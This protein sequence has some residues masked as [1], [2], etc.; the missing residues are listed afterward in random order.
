MEDDSKASADSS[1]GP[2]SF[3]YQNTPHD[4]ALEEE[5]ATLRKDLE[6]QMKKNA[7]VFSRLERLNIS[8][9][10]L[11]DEVIKKD[12]RL[13]ALESASSGDQTSYIAGLKRQIE[14]Q[15]KL[16]EK[17]ESQA[18]IDQE[19]KESYNRELNSLRPIKARLVSTEDSLRELTQTNLELERKAN[20]VDHFKRKLERQV[21]VEGENLRLREQ[22]EVLEANQVAFD[23][24]HE[25]NQRIKGTLKEYQKKFESY[26][27]QI[28]EHSNQKHVLENELRL[29]NAMVEEM[30]ERQRHDERYMREL[31][32]SLRTGSGGGAPDSP[33]APAAGLSLEQELEQSDDPTPNYALEISRLKAEIIVLKSSDRR[34]DDATLRNDL[35]ESER[36]KK[37]LQDNLFELTE[38]HALT[39]EQLSAV[40]SNS[41]SEKLV[42]FTISLL[43]VTDSHE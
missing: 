25:D 13:E 6:E 14:E 26:E 16:I 7:D 37:R 18:S 30:T 42:Q 9:D 2:A 23:K 4:L 36:V 3:T 15:N 1:S 29:Q 5:I 33:S 38:K 35:A 12:K 31:Q 11:Q 21:A 43:S 17:Q 24:V 39:Q 28:V 32:E 10:E 22:L 40:I 19:T 41:S 8:Y 34:T 20:Q 27:M